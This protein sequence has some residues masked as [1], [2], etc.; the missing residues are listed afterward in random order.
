MVENHVSEEK[1]TMKDI[2]NTVTMKPRA[3]NARLTVSK[4]TANTMTVN[5]QRIKMSNLKGPMGGIVHVLDGLLYPLADK[6]VM[7]TLKSCNRF[8]GFVTLAEG[9]GIGEKLSSGTCTS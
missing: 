6:D 7:K 2:K 3:S 4:Q 9:T 8:D 5:G 1:Q